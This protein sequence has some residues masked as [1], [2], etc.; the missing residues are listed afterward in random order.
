MSNLKLL[1]RRPKREGDVLI[2]AG[3]PPFPGG[4]PP[5]NQ[6]FMSLLYQAGGDML[7]P[8][9]ARAAFNTAEGLISM[10]FSLGDPGCH[11]SRPGVSVT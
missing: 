9:N 1:S 3:Y 10:E 2:Q 7:S 11:L 4:G 8:D 6:W 5:G